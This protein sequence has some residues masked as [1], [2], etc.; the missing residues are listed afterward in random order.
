M[1]TVLL[2]RSNNPLLRCQENRPCDIGQ[3]GDDDAD[4][5]GDQLPIDD[6]DDDVVVPV[7]QDRL[8]RVL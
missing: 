3:I 6:I 4:A 8:P 1:G 5:G 2:T 7:L